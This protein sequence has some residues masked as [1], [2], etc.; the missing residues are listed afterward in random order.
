MPRHRVNNEVGE[1]VKHDGVVELVAVR[2][3]LLPSL[4]TLNL[5]GEGSIVTVVAH[6]KS[7]DAAVWQRAIVA[8]SPECIKRRQGSRKSSGRNRKVFHELRQD[9]E[10]SRWLEPSHA[11]AQSNPLGT[12]RFESQRRH[13]IRS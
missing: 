11:G 8:P 10:S 2:S 7:R 4:A 3:V 9:V 6:Q 13:F 1:L 5:K 12:S